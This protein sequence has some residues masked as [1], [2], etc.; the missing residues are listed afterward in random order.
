MDSITGTSL[1]GSDD[2]CVRI[3]NEDCPF[4][5][6]SIMVFKDN[7]DIELIRD[8]FRQLVIKFPRFRSVIYGGTFWSRYK[9]REI[10]DFDVCDFIETRQLGIGNLEELKECAAKCISETMD[11]DQSLWRAYAIYGLEGGK[12]S[13]LVIKVHH[14]IGDGQGCMHALLSLTSD[15]HDQLLE[16]IK[17]FKDK[18]SFLSSESKIQTSFFTY[19]MGF[20]YNFLLFMVMIGYALFEPI[21]LIFMSICSRQNLKYVG[22]VKYTRKTLNW[23]EE[24]KTS[25]ISIIRKTFG[26]SFNDVLVT[27]ITRAIRIYF[28]EINDLLDEELMIFIPISSRVSTN[29]DC[30]NSAIVSLKEQTIEES[31]KH[32]QKRMNELK[33]QNFASYLIYLFYEYWPIPGIY[34]KKMLYSIQSNGHGVITN[35]PGPM[36]PLTFAGQKVTKFVVTPPQN[37]PGGLGI[38]VVS[39][40]GK[41]TC[42]IYEDIMPQYPN[43]SKR[44][45]E[46]IS[47]EF[48]IYL[49]AAKKLD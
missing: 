32:V 30:N 20:L 5:I 1:G 14:C 25:D 2:L 19:L 46:L 43:I 23:T 17:F 42:S 6:S 38:G 8:Q 11:L 7:L 41:V 12:C 49:K 31:I 15:G 24:I 29:L 3:D 21:G 37:F 13:A 16:R 9:W 28:T 39:Y 45:A 40:A 44:I 48:E 36:R 34:F 22:N 27:I 33:K 10:N 26:V 18:N 47:E 4:V 35:V